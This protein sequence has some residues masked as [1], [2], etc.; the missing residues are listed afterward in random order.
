MSRR[1]FPVVGVGASAGG[2]D[3]FRRLLEALPSRPGMA[4]VLVPHLSPWHESQLTEI[5]SKATRMPVTQARSRTRVLP[6]HVYILPPNRDMRIQG[7]ALR[8]ARRKPGPQSAVDVFLASLADDQ[9]GRAIGVV[10]SGEGSDG[11]RG[12]E[13]IKSQGG[14]VFA[15]SE[16]SAGHPSMPR[17]AVLSGCVDFVLSPEGIAQELGRIRRRPGLRKDGTES[18]EPALRKLLALLRLAKGVDF[19]LYK[20]TTVL[21]RIRRRMALLPT[22]SLARYA[23]R[24]EKDPSELEALF[25]DM[26]IH[27]T[28][29]FREPAAYRALLK[30]VYPNL[31]R[32]RSP[33]DP[34]RIWVPGCATGE[35]AYSQALNLLEY[36]GDRA[37][38]IP[39]QI[40]ATDISE[41]AL[42]KAREG[43]YPESIA[44]DVSKE[45]LRRFFKKEA[46]GYRIA[47]PVRDLCVFARQDLAV[48]PPFSNIDLISCRNVLIY[49]GAELQKRL[50]AVFHYALNPHGFL[51]LGAAETV[52]VR[53]DMFA[54]VDDKARIYAKRPGGARV[55]VRLGVPSAARA[56]APETRSEPDLQRETDRALLDQFSPAAVLVDERLDILQVR[57]RT[58]PFLEPSPGKASLNLRS[59]AREGLFPEIRSATRKAFRQGAPVRRGGVELHGD[60]RRRRVD[61]EVAPV[62]IPGLRERCAL[63]LFREAAPAAPEGNQAGRDPESRRISQLREELKESRDHLQSIIEQHE[64]TNEELQS[65]N[66]E[67]VSSNEELQ[68]A[69]E[70]LETAKEELQST[71]EELNTVN[72][73]LANR[74]RELAAANDGLKKSHAESRAARDFANA[75]VDTVFDPLLV[76]DRQ[77]RV[78]TANRAFYD[79]FKTRPRETLGRRLYELGAGQWDLPELREVLEEVLPAGRKVDGFRVQARL[80][81]IGSRTLK[82]NARRIEHQGSGR[83]LLVFVDA[84]AEAAEGRRAQAALH[85]SEADLQTITDSAPVMISYMGPDLR[86]RFVNKCCEEFCG[87]P[88][89]ELIG[90]HVR[91][92][93][94]PKGFG[95]LRQSL[96]EALRGRP[97]RCEIDIPR[98]RGGTGCFDASLVPDLEAGDRVRGVFALLHDITDR[99]QAEETRLLREREAVQKEFLANVS[100]EFRTPVSTIKAAVEEIQESFTG[101]SKDHR[102]LMETIDRHADRLTRLVDKLLRLAAYTTGRKRPRTAEIAVAGLARA[103]IREIA[104]LAR[105]KQL[106]L[107][108]EVSP[109]IKVLADKQEAQ[110]VLRNL[111]ENAIQYTRPGG[112]IGVQAEAKGAYAVVTVHDTGVGVRKKDLERIFQRYQRTAQGRRMAPG[113]SGLGL[114][115]IRTIVE[116]HGGRVWAQSAVGKGSAFRFTL[117]LA[118]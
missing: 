16:G 114:A 33:R 30:R 11:T 60:G 35:E 20:R 56:A 64:T 108:A 12:L 115:L 10:L 44:A 93:L 36:I 62:R 19:G 99:K 38:G 66:E 72:E 67:V 85:K 105:K 45:R 15:Q 41:Q 118:A 81:A 18:D 23:G 65:A 28:G 42:A 82:L 63:V 109:G 53:S 21:R 110:L 116:A 31:L 9:G 79:F 14:V 40:F 90:R 71:N 104:P 6:D 17:S 61:I 80:P 49:L 47:K 1:G 46:R 70:E 86:C 113:G 24:L 27:V 50:F 95:A 32:K 73:E 22:D 55:P 97:G 39:V 102:R 26:L 117:P 58:S 77:F 87:S 52:G 59:M 57:G 89:E 5:L 51:V 48:D 101:E 43:L 91:R 98:P 96:R 68:S 92:L 112:R 75:T 25:K 29:F 88:R 8:L 83:I 7:G 103:C 76:L 13:R 94:G 78:E 54:P 3:A 107:G 106:K 34:I 74:N 69:N 37:P 84:T 2:L 4:F 100:H 111:L